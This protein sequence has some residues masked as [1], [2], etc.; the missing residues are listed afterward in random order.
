MKL[1]FGIKRRFNAMT[2]N[3][4]IVRWAGDRVTAEK[5]VM[6]RQF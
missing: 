2:M 4:R 3:S 6:F 5:P 1:T